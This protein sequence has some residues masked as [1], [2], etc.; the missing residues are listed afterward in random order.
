M[1]S[2]HAA[3]RPSKYVIR[4]PE[5]ADAQ[6][7]GALHV[8]VWRAAYVGMMSKEALAAL[9][10]EKSADRW[11]QI[12]ERAES[13]EAEGLIT[14]IAVHA[15]TDAVAGFATAGT[16]RDDDPPAPRQLWAINV[17]ATHHGT[18]V[19]DQL[20][21]AT[22]A[23][24]PAYLWVVEQ[25]ARAQSFYRRHGFLPDGGRIR[26]EHLAADEIRLVR[27]KV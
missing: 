14:R 2:D 18:G 25:N 23:D 3:D 21:A 24:D 13:A 12:A 6:E 5:I 10:P 27:H 19:A 7:L 11:R 1:P 26:D 22:I 20:M 15:G 9:N 4:R 8:T 16:A 17:L